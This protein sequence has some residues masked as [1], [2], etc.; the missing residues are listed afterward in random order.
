MICFVQPAPQA[1]SPCKKSVD[2]NAGLFFTFSEKKVATAMQKLIVPWS[3]AIHCL[4]YAKCMKIENIKEMLIATINKQQ[5]MPGYIDCAVEAKKHSV[6]F[7]D[8]C[9]KFQE[10]C[11]YEPCCLVYIL[12]LRR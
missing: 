8:F 5:I 12:S 1:P 6:A 11:R 9:K 4:S 2:F 7:G 3:I 10:C